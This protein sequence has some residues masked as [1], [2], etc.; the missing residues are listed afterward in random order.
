MCR[1]GT[2]GSPP[3]RPHQ[4][5]KPICGG[6][7]EPEA[8]EPGG[9]DTRYAHRQQGGDWPQRGR[10]TVGALKHRAEAGPYVMLDHRRR[11][12]PSGMVLPTSRGARLSEQDDNQTQHRHRGQDPSAPV[13][14]TKHSHIRLDMKT[15][16]S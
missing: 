10:V 9:A 4:D 16:K 14:L 15:T 11:G 12:P 5:A 3:Q 13:Q 1:R 7:R 2:F 8:N 6:R